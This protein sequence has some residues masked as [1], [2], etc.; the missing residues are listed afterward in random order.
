MNKSS[1]TSKRLLPQQPPPH[2]ISLKFRNEGV[3]RNLKQ[4]R[5]LCLCYKLCCVLNDFSPLK[6]AHK[7]ILYQLMQFLEG[8]F[9]KKLRILGITFEAR[10]T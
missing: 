10:N 3:W 7:E 6:Q 5:D 4:G 1:C 9:L 8:C 2:P